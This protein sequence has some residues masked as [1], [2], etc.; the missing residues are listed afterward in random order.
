MNAW[1]T[2]VRKTDQPS[3]IEIYK[4]SAAASKR[5]H[6]KGGID[7][8]EVERCAA[9]AA[10]RIVAAGNRKKPASTALKFGSDGVHAYLQ[11]T[12]P[13]PRSIA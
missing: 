11:I 8:A 4:L 2:Q 13:K 3:H 9:L 6:S 1:F 10:A 7:D 5:L 12:Y